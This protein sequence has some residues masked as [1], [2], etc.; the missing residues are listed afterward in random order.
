MIDESRSVCYPSAIRLL[1]VFITNIF[2]CIF[3]QFFKIVEKLEI[4]SIMSHAVVST[5]SNS[6]RRFKDK[7]GGS[8]Q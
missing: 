4:Y 5:A 7:A 3:K 1:R 8:F 6:S 2:R